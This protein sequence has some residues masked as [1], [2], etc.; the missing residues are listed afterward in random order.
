MTMTDRAGFVARRYRAAAII[1]ASLVAV[2]LAVVLAGRLIG[3]PWR[4]AHDT[5]ARLP[6]AQP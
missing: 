5:W 1:G 4:G 2:V 6:A 3:A